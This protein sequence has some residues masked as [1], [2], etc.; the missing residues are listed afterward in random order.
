MKT[1]K[2]KNFKLWILWQEFQKWKNFES[3]YQK[4]SSK[5]KM[6]SMWRG[7]FSYEK[8]HTTTEEIIRFECE[9]CDKDY[10]RKDNLLFQLKD[11]HQHTN[12]E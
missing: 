8:I 3:S 6:Q 9:F 12:Q 11:K 10:S 2:W 5:D 4:Y 7:I 1:Q